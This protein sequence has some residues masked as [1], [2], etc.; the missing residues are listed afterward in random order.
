MVRN[1]CWPMLLGALAGLS[2]CAQAPPELTPVASMAPV[3]HA[4]S[5][6]PLPPKP[7][8]VIAQG[9]TFDQEACVARTGGAA[10]SLAILGSD[11]ELQIVLSQAR[12]PWRLRRALLQYRGRA[13]RWEA[14]GRVEPPRR[15]TIAS[16]IN[17]QSV[18]RALILLAG[19]TLVARGSRGHPVELRVPP[20]GS[21]GQAWF[22][23]LK[24]RLLP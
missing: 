21:E 3:P 1:C 11:A 17:E 9:W 18:S 8:V 5:P 12:K 10:L 24:R 15:L 22:E 23:C 14:V 13:G 6:A 20:G 19:G 4:R 2:A 16:P 7:E